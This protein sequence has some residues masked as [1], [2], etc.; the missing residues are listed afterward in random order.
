MAWTPP[1][2]ETPDC[3]QCVQARKPIPPLI[4]QESVA[5]THVSIGYGGPGS[6]LFLC[7]LDNDAIVLRAD[8]SKV[9]FGSVGAH[10]PC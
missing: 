10:V 8:W 5:F 2:F 6:D 3:L 4:L 1:G 9:C 7:K